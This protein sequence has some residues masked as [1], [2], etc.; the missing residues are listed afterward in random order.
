MIWGYSPLP[1]ARCQL[2][3]PPDLRVNF[4]VGQLPS[5]TMRPV[6]RG[7]TASFSFDPSLLT[8]SVH[9]SWYTL[10][11]RLQCTVP[12]FGPIDGSLRPVSRPARWDNFATLSYSYTKVSRPTGQVLISRVAPALSLQ[13]WSWRLESDRSSRPTH[14]CPSAQNSGSSI[15]RTTPRRCSRSFRGAKDFFSRSKSHRDA[16]LR[17]LENLAE[18]IGR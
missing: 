4:S 12:T 1:Q 11:I 5:E 3:L 8:K 2:P 9:K 6:P 13:N 7:P 16:S 14:V 18:K 17:N 10:S 15:D